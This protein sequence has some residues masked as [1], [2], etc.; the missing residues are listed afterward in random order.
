M[1]EVAMAPRVIR[2]AGA[3]SLIGV[4][5]PHLHRLAEADLPR[6]QPLADRNRHVGGGL[7]HVAVDVVHRFCLARLERQVP[8]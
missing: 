8:Q 7:R 5:S 2:A 3:V 1:L 6:R 4:R